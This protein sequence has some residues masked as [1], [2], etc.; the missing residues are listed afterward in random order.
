MGARGKA[1][2]LMLISS[3][4]RIGEALAL[5]LADVDL[6]RIPTVIII[7]AETTKSGQARISFISAEATEALKEWLK[8]RDDYLKAAV[9]Q[10]T[11]NAKN[12]DDNCIFPFTSMSARSI[13]LNALEKAKLG[14]TDSR[15][16]RSKI[17]P[18]VFRKFFRS[19]IASVIPVDVTEALFGHSGY[20][21]DVY[22]KYPNPEKTLAEFYLKGEASVTIFGTTASAEMQEQITEQGKVIDDQNITI[23]KAIESIQS[24]TVIMARVDF[25]LTEY[26]NKF[27]MLKDFV[28]ELQE[29][30][31]QRRNEK[32]ELEKEKRISEQHGQHA[33]DLEVC[34]N[35]LGRR[36][37]K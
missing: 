10:S 19:M 6:T 25:R 5:T 12:L 30:A 18:H 29:V 3:G 37:K 17:H 13:L 14:E 15:T 26:E 16:N 33:R 2:Y 28:P 7:R 23:K 35:N 9:A 31:I 32:K 27:G 36:G 34:V 22:R 20:L 21:T 24:L 1:L 4:M 11:L 8:V